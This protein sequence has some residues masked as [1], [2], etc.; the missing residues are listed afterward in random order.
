MPASP[1]QPV[2]KTPAKTRSRS[3]LSTRV[4]DKSALSSF[5]TPSS[6]LQPDSAR[7]KSVSLHFQNSLQRDDFAYRLS[8]LGPLDLSQK[9]AI[10]KALKGS[11][12]AE[13]CL[14]YA[15]VR[16]GTA[17]DLQVAIVGSQSLICVDCQ[18][19]GRVI[20][21]VKVREIK[22][23]SVNSDRSAAIL[24]IREG[25]K[26]S[27][28]DLMLSSAKLEDILKALELAIYDLEG[29]CIGA[30][31]VPSNSAF[32]AIFNRLPD[33]LLEQF[34]ASLVQRLT[35]VT[36]KYGLIGESKLYLKQTTL[37]L[38][39]SQEKRTCLVTTHAVYCL[40]E[41]Y[42]C[43]S[44]LA[45]EEVRAVVAV[46][47]KELLIVA[48]DREEQVWSLPAVVGEC[49]IKAAQKVGNEGLRLKWK[50]AK[51]FTEERSVA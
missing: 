43:F 51:S 20:R 5:L 23:I 4:S 14:G 17:K 25:K 36:C 3:R 37:N 26:D 41:A 44:R 28:D 24:H 22:L 27:F 7:L 9:V 49:V 42:N 31:V 1:Q 16:I 8:P 29:F 45:L 32:L 34:Q 6:P 15:E 30:Q 21:R 10:H 12:E 47:G 39:D 38:S 50:S 2:S 19:F 46:T 40:D 48:T 33:A 13:V 18:D 35:E 11:G